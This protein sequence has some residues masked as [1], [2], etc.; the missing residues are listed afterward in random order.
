MLCV[1]LARMSLSAAALIALTAL[2]R[3]LLG[4]RL[5]R[6]MFVALWDVAMLRLLVPLSIPWRFAPRALLGRA[7]SAVAS[8]AAKIQTGQIS[9]MAGH[10]GALGAARVTAN[11]TLETALGGTFEGAQDVFRAANL[12]STRQSVLFAVWLFGAL[13]I[14]ATML[15]RYVRSMRVF[16]QS[17]PDE[18]P[19]TARFLRE[20]P[21]LRRVQVRVSGAIASPLS[22]G[23]LRPVILL[24][25]EMNRQSDQALSFV[26]MHELSHILAMDA[27]RKLLLL[28]CVCLHWMNPAVYL[29][30]L[31]A[32][33]DME[34]R[35]DEHVLA[36]GGPGARRAYA[37]TLLDMEEK[38]MTL[39][40][41][42]SPFS[43]TAIEERIETMK[44][45]KKKS[46]FSALIALT[47][48]CVA[49]VALAT[50]AP[51]ENAQ[52]GKPIVAEGFAVS[53]EPILAAV[54]EETVATGFAMS[55]GD[56][57]D[58]VEDPGLRLS[59]ESWEKTYGKYEPFGLGYDKKSGRLTFAGKIVRHFEDMVPV[60][61]G[62]SAGTVCMFP[63]G[64]VDVLAE[65]DLSAPIV[66]DEDGSYDPI[67]TY[68]I[69]RLREATQE[70][71]DAYKLALEAI[72]IEDGYVFEPD[73]IAT[74]ML[75]EGGV[76]DVDA[77]AEE[78]KMTA[79]D[80]GYISAQEFIITSVEDGEITYTVPETVYIVGDTSY[81][82]AMASDGDGESAQVMPVPGTAGNASALNIVWWTADEYR[83]WME[84][85]REALEALVASG[86]ASFYTQERGWVAWTQEEVERAMA[87]YEDILEQIEN[88]VMV[89]RTIDGRGELVLTQPRDAGQK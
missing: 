85:E 39:S 54:A 58:A 35:C 43:M 18:D 31:L 3:A 26:L 9:A 79:T 36:A 37:L 47:M 67:G 14:G 11:P 62:M 27:L 6:R 34:L 49:V 12:T 80:A 71:F 23:V 22:Y 72:S 48:V 68:P 40:P 52:P 42:S 24:P 59:E 50:D 81:T 17:L 87:V 82:I 89:S 30:L 2:L 8:I 64:E 19:R 66:R 1:T 5:P 84:Q 13:T 55:K 10:T 7:G 20:H 83:A 65:R 28:L 41:V 4:K 21:T 53:Q 60:G 46:A 29:L 76:F 86:G 70:E 25:R 33:R 61:D 78:E 77:K 15:H 69:V 88:G 45:M 63:D 32:S 16:A 44:D 75:V 74:A 57:G 73:S 56:D 38:R 51:E